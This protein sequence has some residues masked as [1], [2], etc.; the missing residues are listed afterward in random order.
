MAAEA[1][2]NL[3]ARLGINTV[4]FDSG[5]TAA[6]AKLREFGKID[7]GK[8]IKAGLGEVEGGL[9]NMTAGLGVAGNMLGALG[10]TGAAAG[11]AIA[12]AFAGA[13][14]AMAFGDE[15]SDTASKLKVS[16]DYLQEMRWAAREFG[17]EFQDADAALEGF[18][19][20]LGAASSGL[21]AKAVKPFAALGLD[22]KSFANV[23]DA[24]SAVADKIAG[25]GSAAEQAAVAEKLGL[26]PILPALREGSAA[27]DAMRQSAHD[28]G[29]VMD[30]EMIQKAADAQ[31][32]L[33]RL[34]TK[35]DIQFK[36]AMV[37]AIPVVEQLAKVTGGLAE[38]ASE[39]AG[40]FSA[41]QDAMGNWADD[42]PNVVEAAKAIWGWLN[43]IHEVNQNL[44]GKP[45]LRAIGLRETDVQ[46]IYGEA[47]TF[48]FA[49]QA[50]M[51]ARADRM[52]GFD[53]SENA[54]VADM[55]EHLRK[56]KEEQDREAASARASAKAQ[57]DAAAAAR[58][59][60]AALKALSDEMRAA[61]QRSA[62]FAASLLEEVSTM[63][64]S[65][66]AVRRQSFVLAAAAAP[67]EAL[68]NLIR[69]L[70]DQ[71]AAQT[72]VADEWAAKLKEVNAQQGETITL[73]DALGVTIPS[74][75]EN[76]AF[77]MDEAARKARDLR[78]DIDDIAAAIENN[79]WTSA[80][81]SLAGVLVKVQKAFSDG[82]TAADKFSAAAG[83]AQGI[84]QA[85]GGTTGKVISGAASG[86]QAG[87]TMSGG[88]PIGA[89]IGAFV[90]WTSA[91]FGSSKAKKQQKAQ[92]AAQRAAEEAQRQ[93]QIA[94][95]ALQLRIDLLKAQGK[96]EEAL[97][98][99][100]QAVLDKLAK[101][102][103][104]LVALQQE[105]WA[106]QEASEAAA[107]AAELQAEALAREVEARKVQRGIMLQLMSLDDAVTGGN[108]AV[109]A[110]RE[111]ELALL[112]PVSQQ[113]KR[114]YYARLDEADALAKQ[115]AAAEA[116]AKAEADAAEAAKAAQAINLGLMRQLMAMDDAVLGT[117]S[118]RD[119]AR[120]DELAKLDETGRKLQTI[121]WA[122]EDEAEAIAKQ[123]AA[124]EAAAAAAEEVARRMAEV[125][126]QRTDL[127]NQLLVA[128]GL[129]A[130]ATERQ[131]EA[132]LA[133]L[134]PSLRGLQSLLWGVE[135]ST[136]AV[137]EAES[138]LADARSAGAQAY[139]RESSAYQATI[140]KF[141]AFA[142]NLKT[143]RTSLDTGP[144]A[145]L[146][147]L[148]QYAR[149]KADF[150]R[151]AGLAASGNE[152]A[153]G[154][155]QGVSEAYLEASKAAQA[156]NVG[157]FKDLGAV[158]RATEAAQKFADQQVDQGSAQLAALQAQLSAL[159]IV[160]TSVLSIG[161]AVG[162]VASAIDA[163]ARATVAKAGAEQ[164]AKNAL[165]NAGLIPKS[166]TG[167]ISIAAN[168][169]ADLAA[170][171]AIYLSAT[172]G[173]SSELFNRYVGANPFPTFAR[174]GY[175]GDIEAL[176]KKFGFATG[177]SFEVGGWGGP[178]SQLVPLHLS[179][180]EVGNI[181]RA[182]VM[183]QL[184]NG[185]AGLGD[186]LSSM[187]A[188]LIAITISNNSM[189]RRERRAEG[190]G[191]YVRGSEPD[192][193][194]K[195]EVA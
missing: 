125:L 110:A 95:A 53:G 141:K 195:T 186:R 118:A 93:Q 132:A 13:R 104:S 171:K 184:L 71:W 181:T 166:A 15:I 101:M 159:G 48:P 89:A 81:A 108:S 112:D 115:Q 138:A 19:K 151:V 32:E 185:V 137:A 92:E 133:A 179:P 167:E 36:S 144:M 180:G 142:T 24:L 70:G 170:A 194:V 168:D 56:L 160:N 97:A 158:K 192:S 131:R 2:G 113:L 55:A 161:Q 91:L 41:M 28:W 33:D 34:T 88:N 121:I 165:A 130:R 111:D 23:E 77:E 175:D 62:D 61:E 172:G 12:V 147:P 65:S 8:G 64:M 40:S 50:A 73:F 82:A 164:A 58:E 114:I 149:T 45:F 78:F 6:Q 140:D 157:Y 106:T 31:G 123:Q 126:Q 128:I 119:A 1:I 83:V 63:G 109:L 87:F 29:S 72:R 68:A 124:S 143:F 169:N 51:G 103:P 120:A 107:K 37:N 176:R 67:T 145:A 10:I 16:T 116:A 90:G 127:E 42:H 3:F 96:A 57:R 20:A 174:L 66:E 129:T 183:E 69:G 146:N 182:D 21:S 60:A 4:G 190:L 43:K 155:L 52:G 79:D 38:Q 102:D 134:D 26:T 100:H 22:P 80:F 94:D 49:E 189:D 9:Q 156:T 74:A 154:Q 76:S 35:I 177:G 30:S 105:L 46:K 85:I 193:P 135:D 5:I 150:E 117:T 122:R 139:E 98:L 44:A 18:S 54:P 27:I 178:D 25:L 47:P 14:D 136:A 191:L 86:A 75:M 11:A 84:G 188:A 152:D 162:N 148:Q 59:R 39:A 173:I 17:V 7:F 163:L 153:L 99:E 187:E